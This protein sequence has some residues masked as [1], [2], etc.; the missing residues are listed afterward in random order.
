MDSLNRM[1]TKYINRLRSL[2]PI[3][4]KNKTIEYKSIIYFDISNKETNDEYNKVRE[5]IICSIINNDIH[6]DYYNYSRRWNNLR[7]QVNS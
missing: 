4:L 6:E 5:Y 1:L 2:I 7:N 3:H